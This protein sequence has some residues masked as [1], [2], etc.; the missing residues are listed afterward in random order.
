MSVDLPCM[1]LAFRHAMPELRRDRIVSFLTQGPFVHTEIVLRDRAGS[2]RAY[3]AFE[4]ISGLTPTKPYRN[5]GAP[6]ANPTR[7]TTLMFSLAPDKGYERAY[8]VI[9]QILATG[10]P[11]NTRD[12]WQCCFQAALPFEQDLDCMHPAAWSKH[13][14]FC[15]QVALLFMRRLTRERV[16]TRLHP[17]VAARL[18][19]VNS[20]GCSPNQLFRILSPPPPIPPTRRLAPSTDKKKR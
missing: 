7:W 19:A 6:R 4:G 12:L 13:G 17:V 8:A 16:I 2:A 15:S 3:S 1:E 11:Y 10:L 9:L 5:L 20:R 18:E 14:V